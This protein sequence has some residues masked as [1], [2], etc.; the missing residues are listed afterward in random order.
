M[1]RYW[2]FDAAALDAAIADWL[3]GEEVIRACAKETLIRDFLESPAARRHKL[4]VDAQTT[5]KPSDRTPKP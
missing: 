4:L 5:R 1:I 2:V 3:A